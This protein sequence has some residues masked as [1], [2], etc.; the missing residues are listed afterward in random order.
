MNLIK[1]RKIVDNIN[2]KLNKCSKD[3]TN[4]TNIL[5]IFK[6][7]SKSSL[8]VL[9]LIPRDKE[10]QLIQNKRGNVIFTWTIGTEIENSWN[11]QMLETFRAMIKKYNATSVI[12]IHNHPSK[13][14][15]AFDWSWEDMKHFISMEMYFN[16]KEINL[17]ETLLIH[18][19]GY[20]GAK[21]VLR[22]LWKD[23]K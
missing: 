3:F 5:K 18:P 21:T 15:S 6:S 19:K 11:L 8:E 2:L 7:L 20:L 14:L 23:F 12:E 17:I 1:T 4:V 10:G 13:K 16:E 9:Y 22:G